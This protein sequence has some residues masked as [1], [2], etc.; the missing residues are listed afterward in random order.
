MAMGLGSKRPVTD[1]NVTPLID[2]VLVLL[3][4]FMVLTPL[5]EKQKFIRV[6]EYQP[7]MQPVPPDSVP[8]DQTVLTA[9]G[10]GNVLLNKQ[11]MTINDAMQRLH[12]AY[13]GRPSKVMFFN[14]EDS[15][16]YEQAV[17]V[18]DAAHGAGVNTIGMMTDP[19]LT[20]GAAPEQQ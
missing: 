17:K 20:G 11:E 16:R 14:A 2:V 4:I 12:V 7:E 13:D 18:L 6:P 10:N 19:P 15:V 1:I 8:P 9:L 3:I 5:A